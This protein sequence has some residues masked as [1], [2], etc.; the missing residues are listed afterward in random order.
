MHFSIRQGLDLKIEG[1]PRQ[2]IENGPEVSTVALCGADFPGVR[3]KFS[4]EP[5]QVVLQGETLFVD[6]HRPDI[7]F[8]APVAG[9]VERIDRSTRG[10]FDYLAIQRDAGG[11]RSFDLS[12]D[13]REVMLTSGLWPSLTA[14]PFGRIPDADAVA[15]AILVTAMD[16]N[17]L[18]ADPAVV[19]SEA[20]QEFQEGLQVLTRLTQGQVFVCQA[21]GDPLFPAEQE[22]IHCVRFSGRHPAGL[23][24]T[25][26]DRLNLAGRPVWQIGYQAVISIGRLFLNGRLS[27]ERVI[28]V[29]GPAAKDPRLVRTVPGANLQALAAAETQGDRTRVVS[30]S[31]LSGRVSVFLGFDHS[32]VC[33]L[34]EPSTAVGFLRRMRGSAPVARPLQPTEA[35]EA[36]LPQNILPV[37]LMRAL[38]IGDDEAAESLGATDLLEE[39]VALLS[40]LCPSGSDYGMLLRQSLDRIAGG[41]A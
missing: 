28:A 38:S 17:P 8:T 21:P 6:R 2:A 24:G 1:S 31:I 33:L 10:S 13:V 22:R 36:A 39:D 40:Y 14:R 15:E 11:A 3:P 27:S 32:Q 25:H 26:V 5:G 41:A 20:Q 37:P 34:P 29:A 4:V 12:A 23:P 35:F 19:V 7:A 30:G 16:S 18:A 9:V